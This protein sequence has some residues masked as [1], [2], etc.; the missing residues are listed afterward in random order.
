MEVVIVEGEGAVLGVNLGRSIVTTGDGDA[1][2][3]NY[4]GEDLFD[5]ALGLGTPVGRMRQLNERP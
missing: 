4:L 3:P 5:T 2:F 1:L